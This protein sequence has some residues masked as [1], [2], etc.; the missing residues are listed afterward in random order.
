M[1]N[2]LK[3]HRT[4]PVNGN[5][6][7]A[8]NVRAELG[9][10]GMSQGQLAA[11]LG[12]S[13]M[14]LSRRLS[15]NYAAEFSASE[16]QRIADLFGISAGDLFTVRERNTPRPGNGARRRA[17]YLL[18]ETEAPIISV[19]S[20]RL[21]TVTSIQKAP[22]LMAHDEPTWNVSASISPM[23]QDGEGVASAHALSTMATLS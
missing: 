1:S 2:A 14:A 18:E 23:Y 12:L 11:D 15:Q 4:P 5:T 20:A 9:Y 17:L 8:A 22:S 7:V 13:E 19:E 16:I 10:A 21:A 6:I 3:D